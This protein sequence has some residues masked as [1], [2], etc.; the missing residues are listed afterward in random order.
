MPVPVTALYAAILGVL[1][2]AF[3]MNVTLTRMKLG[4]SLGDGGNARMSRMVRIHGN[5][6]EYVPMA[7]LLMIAYELNRGTGVV[8][9][10]AGI[11][12]I[13]SRLLHA[14]AL[15]S[16]DEPTPIRGAGQMLTWLI[17][18]VLAILNVLKIM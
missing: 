6:V 10:T 11:A 12:L 2:T 8:L 4:I 15:W 17:I 9:H 14:F 7:L 3:A 13:A 18:M 1:V 16:S 5:A